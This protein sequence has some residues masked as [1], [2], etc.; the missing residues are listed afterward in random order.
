MTK[1]AVKHK[2]VNWA[3]LRENGVLPIHKSHFSLVSLLLLK[4]HSKKKATYQGCAQVIVFDPNTYKLMEKLCYD[5]NKLAS[6]GHVIEEKP[7][8]LKDTQKVMQR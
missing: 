2:D 4:T 5:F 7:Y 6:L 1:A 3:I 8:R